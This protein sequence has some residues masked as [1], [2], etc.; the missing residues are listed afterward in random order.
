[1]FVLYGTTI[2]AAHRHGRIFASEP[3]NSASIS[4]YDV[5]NGVTGGSLS[6]AECLICQLHQHFSASLVTARETNNV[7]QSSGA[8]FDPQLDSIQSQSTTTR[9][10]RA[11]PFTS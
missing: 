7:T 4:T 9:S 1:V 11:P 8:F 2:E 3:S 5:T 6:C 10:G